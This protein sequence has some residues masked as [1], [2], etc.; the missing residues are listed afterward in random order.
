M[1]QDLVQLGWKTGMKRRSLAPIT[2]RMGEE[3]ASH[4]S[5]PLSSQPPRAKRRLRNQKISPLWI[6]NVSN[7]G[8]TVV[9]WGVI[10]FYIRDISSEGR[11]LLSKVCFTTQNSKFVVLITLHSDCT[12]RNKCDVCY[13][14]NQ[15]NNSVSLNQ[16]TKLFKY[17]DFFN[18]FFIHRKFLHV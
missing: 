3:F 11:G 9:W 14:I 16:A 13:N 6:Q 10:R 15:Y 12:L 17:M 8:P 1:N 7:N 2:G 4:C 18:I 5:S